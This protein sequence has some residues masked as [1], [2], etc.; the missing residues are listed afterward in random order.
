MTFS[1][2]STIAV[3]EID[4]Q[5]W[6]L[7]RGFSY[8]GVKNTFTVPTGFGTDFASV[9]RFF[10]WFIPSYGKYTKAAVLHDYL[11]RIEVPK[12]VLPFA[13]A[14]GILRRAMREL[15]VPFLQRWVVWAAV[16]WGSLMK[17]GGRKG[18][19]RTAPQV[20]ASS[21]LA[22]PIVA[23]PVIVISAAMLLWWTME[24]ILWVPLKLGQLYRRHILRKSAKAV[25]TPKVTISV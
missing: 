17:K 20:L 10:L 15:E 12:G 3:E 6:K 9:P 2:G 1:D 4:A 5:N 18:W 14:D 23:L 22:L 8:V 11:W 25:I 21:I 19:W 16:R 7:T 13:D 24:L